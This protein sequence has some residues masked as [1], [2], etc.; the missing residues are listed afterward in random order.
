MKFKSLYVTSIERYSGKT[1]VCLALARRFQA[2]GYR[3]GYMKPLSL[4][5]FRLSGHICDEDAAFVKEILKLEAPAWELVAGDH[6]QRIP[7][8]AAAQ[9]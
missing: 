1:A 9:P 4:Q 8:R 7:A 6:H 5:P 2:D 3:V